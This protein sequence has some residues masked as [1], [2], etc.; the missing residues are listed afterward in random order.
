MPT[1][2]QTSSPVANRILG[3]IDLARWRDLATYN[4]KVGDFIIWHGWWNRWYGVVSE[5]NGDELVII[6]ENL[7]KLLFTMPQADHQ[8]NSVKISLT[9]IRSSRAG[10]YH[11]LQDGIWYIDT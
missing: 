8:K 6:K 4:A 2:P 9:R 5:I 11:I 7:P 10:E 3:N 1:R